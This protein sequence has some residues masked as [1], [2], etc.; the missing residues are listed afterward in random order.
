MVGQMLSMHLTLFHPR[1]CSLLINSVLVL[2]SK[3]EERPP[4]R[5]ALSLQGHCQQGRVNTVLFYPFPRY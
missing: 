3:A 5:Q 4:A 1:F 2:L